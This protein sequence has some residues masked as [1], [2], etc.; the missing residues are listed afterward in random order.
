M[1]LIGF[2]WMLYIWNACI[3]WVPERFK[4]SCMHVR[5]SYNDDLTC[6]DVKFRSVRI[7]IFPKGS[8]E[9]HAY[10]AEILHTCISQRFEVT[11]CMECCN[12]I[13]IVFPKMLYLG[14]WVYWNSPKVRMTCMHI[15]PRHN[16]NYFFR[17]PC[18]PVFPQRF[19]KLVYENIWVTWYI[20]NV[21]V[22]WW[23][24]KSVYL[25]PLIYIS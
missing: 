12:V 13:S 4:I 9:M 17:Y 3:T 22:Y 2:V 15:R 16:V 11:V 1:M 23:V 24:P 25:D 21:V 6:W 5:L 20:C 8:E 7:H 14:V 19:G 10:I 18:M